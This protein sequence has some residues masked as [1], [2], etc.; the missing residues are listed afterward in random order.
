MWMFSGNITQDYIGQSITY[1]PE[2]ITIDGAEY[3]P[4][5]YSTYENMDGYRNLR[6]HISYGFPIS[7]IKCNLNIMAG[8]NWSRTPSMI[9]NEVN[10]TS[11]MGYN[12]MLSLGS[13]IS[14]NIDFTLQWN[15]NYNDARQSLAIGNS[16]N[17]Y[18]SHTA[19][20]TLKWVF[21]KGFT[22]TAAV[23]YNQYIGFTDDYNEDFLICNVY[24]GK[25]LF[26]NQQGEVLIGV[27]D[28]LNQNKAFVRTVGSGYTQ[29][30]WNSV[31]GRYYTIQFNYNLRH[32][33]KKGSQNIDD[34]DGMSQKG[35]KHFGGR[36]PMPHMH[37]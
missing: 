11:N 2:T 26:K 5:Q 34:Y 35:M 3:N 30:T 19:S 32:F 17:Q 36:P 25:K 20:G 16:R 29:N 27:N 33:G 22:L 37:H 10:Y 7:P 28:L 8:V 4:L 24:L 18:F 9:N 21:W 1:N 13:N 23:N 12:A 6:T 14:E 31:I 15:G